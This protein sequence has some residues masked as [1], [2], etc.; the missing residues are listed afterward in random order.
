M[1]QFAADGPGSKRKPEPY[2]GKGIQY[3]GE[4]VRRKQGK[5]VRGVLERVKEDENV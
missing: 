3:F 5:A 4:A 2:N 1:G